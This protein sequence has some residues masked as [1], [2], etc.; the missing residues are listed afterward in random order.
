[1]SLVSA[2]T[3]GCKLLIGGRQEAAL[4]SEA[5]DGLQAIE[6]ARPQ[7]D[8]SVLSP[9]LL[10][11]TFVKVSPDRAKVLVADYD[12]I[13]TD[14]PQISKLSDAD[15]DVW[16]VDNTAYVSAP[17]AS[18]EVVNDQ[19]PTVN[20]SRWG[21]RPPEYRRASVM[22]VYDPA[23]AV[24]RADIEAELYTRQSPFELT[25]AYLGLDFIAAFGNPAFRQPALKVRARQS[26][27]KISDLARAGAFNYVPGS[28][29]NARNLLAAL[30]SFQSAPEV[31]GRESSSV[32][33]E[34]SSLVA[35]VNAA[36]DAAVLKADE[37]N[38]LSRGQIGL[39]DVKGTGS[40]NPSQEGHQNGLA[41]TGEL[42]REFLFEKLVSAVLASEQEALRSGIRKR[43]EE[44]SGV[45]DISIFK[46]NRWAG[47]FKDKSGRQ[48]RRAV[49]N[50]AV[51]DLGFNVRAASGQLQPASILV[52]QSTSRKKNFLSML[53]SDVSVGVERMLRDT[54][55]LLPASFA[56]P[57]AVCVI[58]TL[59]AA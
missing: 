14:F 9:H 3:Q 18:Q 54:P 56:R 31:I 34:V 12:L 32:E 47:A 20:R 43:E 38:Q 29:S 50:Y 7:T 30:E 25:A 24:V 33:S 16:L 11:E 10:K 59:I 8:A 49:G 52:R 36:V 5:A 23:L 28:S 55:S 41:T 39:M 46:E 27:T 57:P 42:L 51:I 26:H 4:K 58:P 2:A 17:Q 45:G 15:I 53:N 48:P 40:L 19:V 35:D 1:M 13:R 37:K 6:Y 44:Q 21:Y 22:P